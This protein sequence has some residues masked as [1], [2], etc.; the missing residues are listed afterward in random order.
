MSFNELN[1]FYMLFKTNICNFLFNDT[2]QQ[3]RY[4]I[5]HKEIFLI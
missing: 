3:S 1:L 2:R 5:F 4:N